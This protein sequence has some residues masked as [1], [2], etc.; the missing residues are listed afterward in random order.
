MKFLVL[1]GDGIGPE[2]VAAA[3]D[4]L[5]ALDRRYDLKIDLDQYD[6]GFASLE[7]TGSTLPPEVMA[8]ATQVDGVLLGPVST[9]DYPPP[10]QGGINASSWFRKRLDLYANIRPSYSR[11]GVP[12]HASDMNLVV[13]RENTEGFYADRNM[14]VGSGEFMPTPDVALAIGKVTTEGCRRIAVAAFELARRRRCRVT[15]V[16]KVNVLKLYSGLFLDQVRHVAA[17]YPDVELDTVIVDAMA[18]LLIRNPQRFDV[19]VTTNMFGDILSD[20]ASEIAGG[21]GLAGSLNAGDK[22]AVAQAAHGSAPDIAGKDEANPVAFLQSVAMLLEHLGAKNDRRD[23]TDAAET[24][25]RETDALLSS[26][27]TRTPDLGGNCG[28]KAFSAALVSA[29]GKG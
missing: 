4:A 10:E 14:A 21:L 7:K 16:H 5:G 12:S 6:V 2:I 29:I 3:V 23:L 19:I 8:L 13:V 24:L 22:F 27:A 18:A 11:P 26:P 17:D 9:E 28:T 25:K 20:E 1:P 15:A